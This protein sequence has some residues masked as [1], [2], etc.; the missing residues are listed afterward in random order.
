MILDG[1]DPVGGVGGSSRGFTGLGARAI[2]IGTGLGGSGGFSSSG[3]LGVTFS[4]TATVTATGRGGAF[5]RF[6][7]RASTPPAPR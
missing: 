2:F 4:I 1:G 7:R 6:A 5:C 3:R